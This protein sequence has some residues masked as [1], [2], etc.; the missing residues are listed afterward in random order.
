MDFYK[1]I[2]FKYAIPNQ[3]TPLIRRVI[4]RNPS[5]FTFHGTGTYIVGKGQVAVID[6]G[7][8]IPEHINSILTST[9]NEKITHI[10]ITHTHKDHS[11][12]ANYLKEITKAKT[13]GFGPHA[14]SSYKVKDEYEESGDFSFIPDI[15]LKDLQIIKTDNWSIQSFYT[16]GHCSNHLCYKLIEENRIFSGDHI[17]G[18]ST[19]VVSPPDGS[20]SDYMKS[21]YK[22]SNLESKNLLPTH[23][24][25]IL[26]PKK[27]I[28]KL[29]KHRIKRENKILETLAS[30]AKDLEELLSIIYINTDK[31]LHKAAKRS[32][33][34]QLF[35]L[36]EKN[37][38]KKVNISTSSSIYKII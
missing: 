13:Y 22:I 16:P 12:A 7:P 1:E 15:N 9:K 6:P 21:L 8:L 14:K 32:L 28:D 20:M 11:E 34:A 37:K 25:P 17:M 5:N 31:S 26:E 2:N 10:F 27:Y 38:I 3:L 18:W 35:F 29:I 30:G 4:A 19:T 33:L 23:G 24:P 36:I